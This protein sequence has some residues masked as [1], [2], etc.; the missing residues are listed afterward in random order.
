MKPF[1]ALWNTQE[2]D[3]SDALQAW[4]E[5]GWQQFC[6]QGLPSTKEEDWKY[7]NVHELSDL[8]FHP[9]VSTPS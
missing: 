9:H 5:R 4:R 8:T 7:T 2:T 3:S 6:K 1:V